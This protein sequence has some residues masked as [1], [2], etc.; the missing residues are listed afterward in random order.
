MALTSNPLPSGDG[1]GLTILGKL[2]VF[3]FFLACIAGAAWWM[4]MPGGT[5]S[6][7]GT[8][9]GGG[10]ATTGN[11]TDPGT[12]GSRGHAGTPSKGEVTIGI[13]YGT[14]KRAWLTWAVEEFRKSS[15]GA[16]IEVEL[17]PLG[18]IEAAHAILREDDK[19]K[20]I[21]VWSPA[22]AIY[23]EVLT[24]D[25][26]L[27][28]AGKD[29][30]A[31]GEL[32]AFTPM[33]WV[34][35]DERAK[36]FIAKHSEISFR[37]IARALTESSGSWQVI[38]ALTDAQQK[39]QQPWGFLKYGHTNPSESNSGL[40]TLILQA[41][42]FAGKTT[43]LTLSDVTG[44]E[45]L[46][47]ATPLFKSAIASSNSTGNFMREMV[48]RGPSSFDVLFVYESTV[49]EMIPAAEGRW[50]KLRV[51]YPDRNLWNDNPYYVLDV[52]WSSREQRDAAATF[53]AFLLSEPI[54]RRALDLGF[55]PA[56][57]QVPVKGPESPF[58]KFADYGLRIDLPTMCQAPDPRVIS[59]LQLL[60]QRAKGS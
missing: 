58:T 43:G 8:G 57:V 27:K 16:H 17:I 40:M 24:N 51:V 7:G 36:A 60:W 1:P 13:A 47:W 20:R 9:N 45:Y 38:R 52:P 56:N 48:Q 35:W 15:T 39:T 23:R 18:S 50:D 32:L 3:A 53:Q 6:S 5:L 37:S 25:W 42:D 22:S 29:P 12:K 41:Y 30:I 54:Q 31:S 11:P 28:H 44:P 59:E 34:M 14:E 49:I 55:R 21:H 4:L 26:E 19:A 2:F 10:G 33:V 46:T